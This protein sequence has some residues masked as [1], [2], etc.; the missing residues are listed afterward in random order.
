MPTCRLDANAAPQWARVRPRPT[1]NLFVAASKPSAAAGTGDSLNYRPEASIS[2]RCL[3]RRG[4]LPERNIALR[5]AADLM[6]QSVMLSH[7][8]SGQPM[9]FDQLRRSEFITLLGG[10]ATQSAR[11]A[12]RDQAAHR[13]ACADNR[14]RSGGAAPC[15][16]ICAGVAAVWLDRR[17]QRADRLPLGRR[18]GGR[19]SQVRSGIDRARA[20]CDLRPRGIGQFAAIQSV[21]P[22]F[23]VELTP[24]NVLGAEQVLTAFARGKRRFD[25]NGKRGCGG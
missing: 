1:R 18:Q 7:P 24:V 3:T 17:P 22:S 6:R 19:R 8:G 10:A 11:A 9:Q 13:R 12:T 25:R 2:C 23:G 21:A 5:R 20:G 4:H 16:S 15:G 14:R